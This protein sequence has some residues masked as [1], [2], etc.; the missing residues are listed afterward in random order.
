M[1]GW[2]AGSRGHGMG[3]TR[4]ASARKAGA[5]ASGFA[6]AGCAALPLFL[7]YALVFQVVLASGIMAARAASAFETTDLCLGSTGT[8]DTR[9]GADGPQ[10]GI[11][12][13]PLCLSRVDAVFLPPPPP[14]P[15]I[16]RLAVRI[17]FEAG[18]TRLLHVPADRPPYSPRD[19][20]ARRA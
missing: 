17:H 8:D 5:W 3:G 14:S 16:E 19:P 1:G 15:L 20:P 10:A 9:E 12:H 11:V 13:C 18:G 2:G 6:R 4:A 7:A